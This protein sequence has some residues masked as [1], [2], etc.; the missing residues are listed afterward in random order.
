MASAMIDQTGERLALPDLHRLQ[1]ALALIKNDHIGPEV[2]LRKPMVIARE[3]GSRT[4]ELRA[5]I[6]LA[7]LWQTSER[8]EEARV[9]L[10]SIHDGIDEGDCVE[11]RATAHSILADISK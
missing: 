4:W 10:Q 5:A 7:R 6:D 9:L 8:I 3:Q 11:D 2:S 1:A